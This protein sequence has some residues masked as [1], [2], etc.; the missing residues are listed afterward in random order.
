MMMNEI[1][2]RAYEGL[3]RRSAQS[4]Q[5]FP[6]M[7]KGSFLTRQY[8]PSHIE[9]KPQ[10]LDWICLEPLADRHDAK[11]HLKDWIHYLTTVELNDGIR[12]TSF[13]K[14][15]FWWELDYVMSE[16]FPTVS[17]HISAWVDGQKIELEIDVSFNLEIHDLYENLTFHPLLG[18]NFKLTQTPPLATQIAWKLHQCMVNPRYKDIFDLTYLLR[19]AFFQDI[20][21]QL[22]AVKTLKAE[23]K[24]DRILI[25]DHLSASKLIL[26]E[27]RRTLAQ[28]WQHERQGFNFT[29]LKNI[30]ESFENF[31]NHFTQAL[32]DTEFL[33]C[34]ESE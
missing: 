15:N 5:Y 25:S 29:D 31:W 30:P 6:F 21:A 20:F 19:H 18:H 34:I 11:N 26:P 32:I 14:D 28:H 13:S 23:C 8:F 4:H 1:T 33:E 7:L 24:R 3:I 9:R 17:T 12:Y 22:S 10:D 2:Q 27:A 16:D